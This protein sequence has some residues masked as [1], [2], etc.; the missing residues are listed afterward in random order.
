MEILQ[1][2]KESLAAYIHHFKREAKRCN[3][4][5]A[6]TIRIFVKGLKDAHILATRVYEKGPQ[7]LADA[8]SKVQKL[9][10]VQLL[11]D[12][13]LP[14]ST[15]DVMSHEEDQCFQCQELGHI[16]CHCPNVCCFECKEYG[17]V[18]V[19]CPHHIQPSGTPACHHRQDFN[20]RYHTRSTSRHHHQDRYRHS[21][22]RS[23][24]CHCRYRSHS[25]HD[26]HRGHSRSHHKD[27]RHHHR[28]TL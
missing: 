21:R 5:N 24:S 27:S 1:E 28:S 6:A 11:T 23:Q 10:A 4:T 12:T 13:L 2:E 18:V 17:H 7:T 3:F 19:E 8:I 25:H 9:Q 20:T 14:S 16:A 22:T 26:S 15:V